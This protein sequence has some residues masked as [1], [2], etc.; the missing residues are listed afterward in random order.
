VLLELASQRADVDLDDVD[1]VGVEPPDAGE[2]LRLRQDPVRVA[3]EGDE[4]VELGPGE[5]DRG[6]VAVDPSR[7]LVDEDVADLPGVGVSLP[8][9]RSSART[10]ARSSAITKGLTR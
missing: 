6:T 7:R 4:Q 10:R 2:Q 1:V 5:V 9:R 8:L 3:A